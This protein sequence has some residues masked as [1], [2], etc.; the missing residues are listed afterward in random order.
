MVAKAAE[1]P[2][3]SELRTAV[4]SDS[5]HPTLAA[6]LARGCSIEGLGF[7][8]NELRALSPLEA[9]AAARSSEWTV[10]PNK[11]MKLTSVEHIGRSQ[12]VPSVRQTRNGA[13]EV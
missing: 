5:W 3:I 1:A 8:A 2:E 4:S 9:R 6:K 13:K 10:L 11:E 7:L 12:I